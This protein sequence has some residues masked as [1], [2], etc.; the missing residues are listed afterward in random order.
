[1]NSGIYLIQCGY[2]KY[3]GQ[4]RNI[5]QR[6][7]VHISKLNCNKHPNCYLQN[8]WNKYGEES[9]KFSILE[10]CLSG[11]LNNREIFWIEKL[12]T[13]NDNNPNGMNLVQGGNSKLP[14]KE[15]KQKIGTFGFGKK[16]KNA[17]SKYFGVYR[18]LSDGKYI[19]WR[20]TIKI[21]RIVNHL[22]L[23]KE[24][25]QAAQAYNNYVI[26]NGLPNPLNQL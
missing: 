11:D 10:Y 15:T 12:N 25:I 14:S 26:Q 4:A 13:F 2:K 5:K 22:G 6:W 1:M 21:N 17:S 19:Y 9:F 8:A 3:V 20:V 16:M 7:G 24:E 23:F 18:F